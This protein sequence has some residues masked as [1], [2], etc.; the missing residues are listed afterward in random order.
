MSN[1][2]FWIEEIADMPEQREDGSWYDL[3]TGIDY[4]NSH[5]YKTGGKT[6]R[7]AP[8]DDVKEHRKIAK[9]YG[10]KALTG[11]VKQKV[12][13][14]SLRAKVLTSDELSDEEKVE[15]LQVVNVTD[16]A[17]FWINN[18]DLSVEFFTKKQILAEAIALTELNNKHYDTLAR[19][20]PTGPKDAARKEITDTLTSNKFQ[21]GAAFGF[22]NFDP[23]NAY[24]VFEK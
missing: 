16:T 11:S 7:W 15:F 2:N 23:Y 5:H 12:W 10:A 18:K 13:A 21:L 6:T 22:P 24:G 14:E 3:E 19:G 8:R 4:D 1:F 20:G 17:K 9:F